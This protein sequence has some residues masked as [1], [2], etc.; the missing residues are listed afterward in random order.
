LSLRRTRCALDEPGRLH[1]D[2]H[3]RSPLGC[4][5]LEGGKWALLPPRRPATATFPRTR[6]RA[7]SAEASVADASMTWFVLA[8]VLLAAIVAFEQH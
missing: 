3:L 1:G 8:F 6:I 4:A 7:I 5:T 2:V